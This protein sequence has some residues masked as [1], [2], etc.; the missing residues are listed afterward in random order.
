[1]SLGI[2]FIKMKIHSYSS[3]S[4]LRICNFFQK[5]NE[6]YK[7]SHLNLTVLESLKNLLPRNIIEI[8][9]NFQKNNG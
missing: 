6:R 9:L 7:F 3:K 1:M 2:G 5:K 8:D 4:K